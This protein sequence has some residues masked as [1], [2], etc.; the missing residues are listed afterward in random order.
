MHWDAL[1]G[2]TCLPR[3][4]IRKARFFTFSQDEMCLKFLFLLVSLA[5]IF[6]GSSDLLCRYV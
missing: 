5:M 4:M 3:E 1:S 2:H 6:V